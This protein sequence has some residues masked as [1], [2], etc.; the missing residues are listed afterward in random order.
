[1]GRYRGL[2]AAMQVYDAVL[3]MEQCYILAI[4]L[5]GQREISFPCHRMSVCGHCSR[6]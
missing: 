1:M 6:R 4:M 5:H 2:W 3:Y